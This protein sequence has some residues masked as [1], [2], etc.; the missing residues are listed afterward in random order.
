MTMD[1]PAANFRDLFIY[2]L[3]EIGHQV[4]P[5][6]FLAIGKSQDVSPGLLFSLE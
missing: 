1:F 4:L 3:A 5:N 2:A 6:N